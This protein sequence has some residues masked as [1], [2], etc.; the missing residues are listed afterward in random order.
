MMNPRLKLLIND[1]D[2][3]ELVSDVQWGRSVELTAMLEA[4]VQKAAER[5]Q[6][7]DLRAGVVDQIGAEEFL[8]LGVFAGVVAAIALADQQ[9]AAADRRARL[10]QRFVA[11]QTAI[12]PAEHACRGAAGRGQRSKAEAGKDAG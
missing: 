1:E 6:Y 4:A 3:S 12:A 5:V 10:G 9:V 7:I 8:S 11:G 2:V